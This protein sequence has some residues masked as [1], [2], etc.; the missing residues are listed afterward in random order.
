M[1]WIT[2]S[3]DPPNH[4]LYFLSGFFE[5]SIICSCS[6]EPF[7]LAQGSVSCPLSGVTDKDVAGGCPSV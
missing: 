3:E 4:G 6:Y 7:Q 5:E 2:F 1:L